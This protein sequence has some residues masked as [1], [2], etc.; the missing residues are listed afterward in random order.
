MS[1]LSEA[2]FAVGDSNNRGNADTDF[3]RGVSKLLED[4]MW[5]TIVRAM[6]YSKGN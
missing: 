6:P 5:L 2:G 3:S 4:D 1:I